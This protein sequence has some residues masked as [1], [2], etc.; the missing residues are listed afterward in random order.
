MELASEEG[1]G[2]K[3]SG[4]LL[5]KKDIKKTK[6]AE[7]ASDVEEI[8]N[9]VKTD[10][11]E[12]YTHKIKTAFDPLLRKLFDPLK[13]KRHK[14]TCYEECIIECLVNYKGFCPEIDLEKL[15]K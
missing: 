10:P 5:R 2:I 13:E 6:I 15:C 1:L 14:K 7:K 3:R 9:D 11:Q 12:E 4:N 8:G